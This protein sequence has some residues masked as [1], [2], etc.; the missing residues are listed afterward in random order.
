MSDP[1]NK[2]ELEKAEEKVAEAIEKEIDIP[3]S[4]EEQQMLDAAELEELEHPSKSADA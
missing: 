1:K 2:E 3:A 4:I